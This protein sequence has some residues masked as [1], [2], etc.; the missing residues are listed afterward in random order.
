MGLILKLDMAS[1]LNILAV[2]GAVTF[3]GAI[4]AGAF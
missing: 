3:I 1:M 4:I 2:C